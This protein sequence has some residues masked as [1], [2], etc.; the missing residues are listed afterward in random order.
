MKNLI[1][2]RNIRIKHLNHSIFLAVSLV[3]ASLTASPASASLIL[4]VGPGGSPTPCGGGCGSISGK[5][6]GWSFKVTS[7]IKVDGIGAWDSGA[8][9]I[10]PAIQAGLWNESGSLLASVTISNASSPEPSNGN[11]QW[12][13]ENIT[14]QTLQPGTYFTGLTF[15]DST[16]LAQIGTA[17][18]TIPEVTY[19]NGTRSNAGADSGLLFPNSPFSVPIFGP[20]LRVAQASVPEPFTIFGAGTAL[21]FGTLFKRKLS[22]KQQKEATKA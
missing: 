4:D 15:F 7:P 18:T 17:F 8:D 11:G 20:T 13:F 12:L 2:V 16:P 21:G 10:G 3:S 22:K 9:G 19:L 14:M 5:T 6:F 1:V